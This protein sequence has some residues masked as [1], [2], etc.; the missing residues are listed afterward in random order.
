MW[1][2]ICGYVLRVHGGVHVCCICLCKSVYVCM[3]ISVW[4]LCMPGCMRVLCMYVYTRV[5]IYV[6]V[7]VCACAFM[8]TCAYICLVICYSDADLCVCFKPRNKR[9]RPD[10]DLCL[11]WTRYA[12]DSKIGP[13]D[14][15]KIRT[16]SCSGDQ[17]VIRLQTRV[18]SCECLFIGLF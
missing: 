18:I 17:T 14:D 4:V 12:G 5:Y 15:S 6:C 11:L 13:W 8:C 10:L 7:G 16:G 1:W 2:Y 3:I 9:P